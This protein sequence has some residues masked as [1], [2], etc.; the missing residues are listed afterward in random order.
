[1]KR[2]GSDQLP[3]PGEN[4]ETMSCSLQLCTSPARNA[5]SLT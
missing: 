3:G 2:S 4:S 1:M 5:Q